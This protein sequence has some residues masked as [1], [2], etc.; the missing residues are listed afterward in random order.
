MEACS[1]DLRKRVLAACDAGHGT[2][3]AAKSF[4]VSPAWV[5][6]LMGTWS[7]M[8]IR[9]LGMPLGFASWAWGEGIAR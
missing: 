3:Q 9:T 2:T 4:E 8:R 6:R 7:E 5:R 1:M